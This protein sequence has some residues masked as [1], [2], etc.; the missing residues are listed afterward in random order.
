MSIGK[1]SL[2]FL[3][4][5]NGNSFRV[6]QVDP[7]SNAEAFVH[8]CGRTARIGNKGEQYKCSL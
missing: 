8:R 2:I 5:F 7:P 3:F 6:V 1:I 4:H